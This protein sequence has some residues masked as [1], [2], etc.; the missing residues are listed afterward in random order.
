MEYYSALK[1]NGTLIYDTAW[2][3]LENTISSKINQTKKE[4]ILYD[5]TSM[6]DLEN[7]IH[8]ES[9]TVVTRGWREE[10]WKVLV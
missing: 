1:R 9:R 6:R 10:E 3:N 4:Q 8:T 5:S 2:M 7:K